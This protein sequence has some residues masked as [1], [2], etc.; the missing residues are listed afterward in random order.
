VLALVVAGCGGSTPPR[1][2][3]SAAASSPQDGITA[4]YRYSRCM[5]SHGA[6]GFPDPQV[7][8]NGNSVSVMQ[9]VPDSL[10]HSPAFTAA[11][12]ACRGIIP[13]PASPS[14]EA[15]R[16]RAKAEALLAFAR[17]LR[18]H[19]VTNFPDPSAQGELRLPAVEAAGVDIH[20]PSFLTAAKACVGVTHGMITAAQVEQAV[21]SGQ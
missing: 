7:H 2:T 11:Q 5:R 20:A 13:A 3:T 18:N 17:C 14:Q 19:G 9:R 8:Q 16:Q 4:A 6:T 10:A 21:Q 12:K 1:S 15:A